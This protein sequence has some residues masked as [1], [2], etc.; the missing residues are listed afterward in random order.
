MGSNMSSAGF[1]KVAAALALACCA[2]LTLGTTDLQSNLESRVLASHNRER[3]LAGI[4]LL[5]WDESLATSARYWAD[6]LGR[7]NRLEHSPYDPNDR[8][9]QGENLWA[10]T[11]GHYS[12][13]NMVDYWIQEKR[14]FRPGTFPQ[15]S[16]T[17]RIEDVGHYTQ[18]MW[19]NTREVGC[20]LGQGA[21]FD[22]L[23]C[24]YSSVGNVV[25]Q[26]P[27]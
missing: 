5:R 23:V 8:N 4:P 22:I 26:K 25:G 16:Q 14:N 24:R 27:F 1:G 15:N 12:A 7:I 3:D 18:V 6:H 19:R 11:R 2:P 9:P 17:G 10:G 13:E 21:E 20:A